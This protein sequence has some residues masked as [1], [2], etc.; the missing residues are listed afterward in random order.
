MFLADLLAFLHTYHSM[1]V[2]MNR[3]YKCDGD[4]GT[5]YQ[6]TNSMVWSVHEIARSIQMAIMYNIV[7]S[8][9]LQ[10]MTTFWSHRYPINHILLYYGV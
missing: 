3:E 9:K 2:V 8:R 5:K 10:C 4:V 6:V 1:Y 7:L